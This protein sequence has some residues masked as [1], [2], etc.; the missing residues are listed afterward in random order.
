MAEREFTVTTRTETIG[1]FR[2]EW[3]TGKASD[4]STYE[5]DT[6]VSAPPVLTLNVYHGDRVVRESVD[7]TVMLTEWVK[8]I[9]KEMKKEAVHYGDD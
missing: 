5:L 9:R 4:G 6:S 1:A 2:E 7:L 8:A 3:M